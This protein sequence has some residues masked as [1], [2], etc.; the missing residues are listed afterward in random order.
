MLPKGMQYMNFKACTG[1]LL[2]AANDVKWLL[3][4]TRSELLWR[5]FELLRAKPNEHC[6]IDWGT[7]D[8]EKSFCEGNPSSSEWNTKP[9]NESI[10]FP[11]SI[12]MHGWVGFLGREWVQYAHIAHEGSGGKNS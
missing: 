5:L 11:C 9:M 7:K 6:F 8:S 12:P 3:G 4:N 2:G 1:G 10:L